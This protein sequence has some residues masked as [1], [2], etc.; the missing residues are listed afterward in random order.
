M[1]RSGEGQTGLAK[2]RSGPE[3]DGPGG[4]SA[5]AAEERAFEKSEVTVEDL[6]FAEG[7]SFGAGLKAAREQL[8]LTLEDIADD[9]KV[10]LTQLRAIENMDLAKLPSRPF[11]LGYVRAYAGALGLDPTQAAMRFRLDMPDEDDALPNP[12]GVDRS[13]DPRRTLL[14]AAGLAVLAAIIAWNVARRAMD[15]RVE[16]AAADVVE[17]APEIVALDKPVEL[18][19][20]L[21]P[22]IEATLPTPYITPGLEKSDPDAAAA[23]Q[24]QAEAQAALRA[25]RQAAPEAARQFVQR[26]AI[27][28]VAAE[29]SRL[30]VQARREVVLIIRRNPGPILDIRTLEEGESYR[31]P[32]GPGLVV[33][34]SMPSS[35]DY[36]VD[37]ELRGPLE[38]AITQV[39]QLTG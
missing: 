15:D 6:A 16:V 35:M 39:A 8:G 2:R 27:Y 20:A 12:I 18:G 3:D 38:Q 33:D 14:I 7:I 4:G 21:P 9:T 29:E 34:V 5:P 31:V 11:T 13:A 19:E 37:G 1:A 30:T 28:G 26:G 23:A 10:G 17:T 25:A 32:S 24:A 22:P 36:Y